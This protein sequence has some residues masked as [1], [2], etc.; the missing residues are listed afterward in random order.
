MQRHC[1]DEKR[2]FKTPHARHSEIGKRR[3]NYAY[4]GLF[5]VASRPRQLS[6]RG[7]HTSAHQLHGVVR[8]AELG[9]GRRT[10]LLQLRAELLAQ[11]DGS[12]AFTAV[13]DSR[14]EHAKHSYSA[15]KFR[16]RAGMA[17]VCNLPHSLLQFAG[18]T[19]DFTTRARIALLGGDSLLK[20]D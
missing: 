7:A 6:A 17:R 19:L 4:H 13:E 18:E 1:F 5:A 9:G 20:Q 10:Q 14:T 3:I 16:M 8:I 15:F 2:Q 11:V 12:V